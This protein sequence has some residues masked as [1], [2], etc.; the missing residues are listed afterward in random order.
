MLTDSTSKG[1]KIKRVF[2]DL[3]RKFEEQE[4]QRRAA[5][6]AM[7]YFDLTTFPIEESVL[8]IVLREEAEAAG[9][10]PFF[11]EGA[12]LRLA[13]VEP[14]NPKL[15]KLLTKLEKEKFKLEIYLVSQSAFSSALNQYRKI[16]QVSPRQKDEVRLTAPKHALIKLKSLPEIGEKLLEISATDL[17]DLILSGAVSMDAS[18]VHLEPGKEG[19]KIRFRVDG[20]LQEIVTLPASLMHSLY[21]RIKLL[22]NLKLNVT[23]VAQDG[24]F[25]VN[26]PD[27]NLDLRVSVL[28]SAFGESIVIRLLGLQQEKLEI[29]NLGLRELPLK[30]VVQA[31]EKPNGMLL[32]TGPTGSG[33]TTTLYAFLNHLNKPGVKIITLEEPIEYKLEGI[34]QMPVAREHGLDFA[35]GLRSVLRQDPDIVMVGEIRDYETAETAAQ[36]ALTGHLVL[37]TLHTNDAA[38]AI[39]RLLDLGVKPVTLAPALSI[40]IAQRLLRRICEHCKEPYKPNPEELRQVK[41]SLSMISPQSGIKVPEQLTFYH[42]RGC[43]RCHELGYS[44]RFGVFEVFA[45]DEQIQEKIYKQVSTNEIKKA[46]QEQ[47][48]LTMQQD[49]ILKALE[50]LTDLAEVWRVTEE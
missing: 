43:S 16:L 20:V 23:A 42:S 48:M 47:G 33:K 21:S 39:P 46:A 12:S 37:S 17:L 1:E 4:T 14:Q 50:G 35:Q 25:S 34:V 41:S 28:P 3:N 9:A 10:I 27:K 2:T 36:A 26:L 15:Q 29:K 19:L 7:P 18:D 24:R 5:A 30:T 8:A 11:K 6:S 38:G 45:V 44:G 49:G 40:L 13:V 32:T 22:S 31:L